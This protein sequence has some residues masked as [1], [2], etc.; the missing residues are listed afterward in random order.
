VATPGTPSDPALGDTALGDTDRQREWLSFEDPEEHRTWLFDLTFLTSN[1]TCI[2]GA[3][4]PGIESEPAV[5]RQLGCCTHGAYLS[6]ADDLEHVIHCIDELDDSTWQLRAEA[7]ELGGPLWQDDDGWWRTRVVGG[8]CVF[9]NRPDHPAGA[10]CAFHQLA[11]DTGRP[12]MEVKPEICWQAPVRRE[13]HETVTG[14]I[15]TMV[16]EWERRDWGGEETDVWWWCTDESVAHVGQRPVY[17]EMGLELRAI[18]GPT[19]YSWL[20]AE[21]DERLARTQLLP[22]PVVRRRS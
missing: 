2:Y 3:G 16:R 5:E 8:A 10:G 9:Q 17:K 20:E 19:V 18:C 14:H 13:D 6:D 21:L 4:C 1:W 15:Y 22:H 11:T 7:E 12:H